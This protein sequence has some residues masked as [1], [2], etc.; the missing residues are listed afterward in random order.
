MATDNGPTDP[1]VHSR[2]AR[3]ALSEMGTHVPP[4]MATFRLS[5]GTWSGPVSSR[6]DLDLPLAT[7]P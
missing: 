7:C 5:W 2:L 1:A 6:R 3:E 4:L